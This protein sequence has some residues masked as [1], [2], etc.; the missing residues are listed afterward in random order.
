MFCASVGPMV[1]RI[2]LLHLCPTDREISSD[3]SV[4]SV[5]LEP[6]PQLIVGEVKGWASAAHVE[7][8][9]IPGFWMDGAGYD[10]PIGEKPSPGE[11]VVYYLHG[12]AFMSLTAHPSMAG[13]ARELMQ[14]CPAAKRIFAAEYRLCK[15]GRTTT[16][17]FPAALIDAMLGFHYLTATVGFAPQDVYVLGDSAGANLVLALARYLVNNRT[18][19]SAHIAGLA[20]PSPSPVAAGLILMYP[21][22]DLGTSH[23]TPGSSALVQTDD[24]LPDLRSGVMLA[25]R[26]A[27]IGPLGF[28]GAN[29]NPYLSPGSIHADMGRISFAGFPRT[30]IATGGA[31][32]FL[33]AALSLR[34]HMARDLGE[35]RDGVTYFCARDDF[36]GSLYIF[37]REQGSLQTL[38]VLTQ[39]LE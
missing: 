8:A 20:S 10:T 4:K 30:F 6:L 32:R 7:A 36:H 15:L 34:A 39:W 31:E 29:S 12:G 22:A 33:D 35:G 11:K 14:R 27:Y 19:L 16:N 3:P 24:L 2:D 17:P 1:G 23:E 25:A 26:K 21:W 28:A 13:G 9:R 38:A 5:W 18:A 37:P